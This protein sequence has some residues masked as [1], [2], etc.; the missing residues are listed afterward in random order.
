MAR[1]K[2]LM[3]SRT[4]CGVRKIFDVVEKKIS[5]V[6][7]NEGVN[8]IFDVVENPLWCESNVVMCRE[9]FVAHNQYFL[10]QFESLCLTEWSTAGS[11]VF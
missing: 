1:R 4:L 11:I 5:D 3:W 2:S 9:P 8:K 7:E 10:T 6:A